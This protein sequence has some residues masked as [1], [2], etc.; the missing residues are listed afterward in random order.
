MRIRSTTLDLSFLIPGG[1]VLA[2]T[3]IVILIGLAWDGRQQRH[4]ADDH[5]IFP[6]PAGAEKNLL[7]TSALE[8]WLP[9]AR[10]GRWRVLA[11]ISAHGALV[12]RAEAADLRDAEEIAQRFVDGVGYKFFEILMYVQQE[13]TAAPRQIRRVRWTGRELEVLEF[14]SPAA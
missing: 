12:V 7:S 5:G 2:G 8:C 4:A 14:T 10:H 9:S 3:A 11:R 13:A 6:C 1:T